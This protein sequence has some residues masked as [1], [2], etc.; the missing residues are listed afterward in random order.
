MHSFIRK[1]Q[2]WHLIKIKTGIDYPVICSSKAIHQCQCYVLV[3]FWQMKSFLHPIKIL[4]NLNQ[5]DIIMIFICARR[6]CIITGKY[7]VDFRSRNLQPA[8]AFE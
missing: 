4:S 5:C 2:V 3:R 6:A 8:N 7:F 1:C